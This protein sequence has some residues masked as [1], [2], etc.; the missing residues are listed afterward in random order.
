MADALG[1]S[2]CS[3]CGATYKLFT[4]S[5]RD[6]QGLTKAWKG[7]HE[8]TCRN[9]TPKER[10]KWAKKYIGKDSTESSITVDTDHEGFTSR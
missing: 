8:R 4:I 2:Y 3:F 7:R 9:R 6:M 5:N 1:E 10:L